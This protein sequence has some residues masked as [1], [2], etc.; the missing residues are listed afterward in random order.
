MAYLQCEELPPNINYKAMAKVPVGIYP[1]PTYIDTDGKSEC[2]TETDFD[3]NSKIEKATLKFSTTESLPVHIHLAF[4][5]YTVRGEKY[6]IGCKEAPYPIIKVKSTTGS[7]DWQR[8]II[9]YEITFTARKALV[10]CAVKSRKI[11]LRL[12]LLLFS[13]PA[14]HF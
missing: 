9:N 1:T 11:V 2:D 10:Q 7:P 5:I 3:N 8:N 13:N 6:I 14:K 12:F 4:V